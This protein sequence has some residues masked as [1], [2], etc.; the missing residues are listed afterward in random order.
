MIATIIIVITLSLLI[1]VV[2]KDLI[3]HEDGFDFI[4]LMSAV[5]FMIMGNEIYKGY[6]VD[7]TRKKSIE[8]ALRLGSKLAVHNAIE[9][10][11]ELR[12]S[13]N[14]FCRFT[15]RPDSDYIDVEYYEGKQNG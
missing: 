1:I 8:E 12:D 13:D 6:V 15:L 5:V 4:C 7:P 9:Y 3:K 11:K 14:Y 10:N 2:T